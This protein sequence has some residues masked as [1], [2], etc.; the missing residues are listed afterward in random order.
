MLP[1][2]PSQDNGDART[3]LGNLLAA[4]IDTHR[5]RNAIRF[6][7]RCFE[8]YVS[9]CPVPFIS[10]GLIVTPEIR[11]QSELYLPISDIAAVF[12]RL[13]SAALTYPPMLSSTPFHNALS[14]ADTFVE[15]P[16]CLQFSVNPALLLERLL[17]DR[18]LLT[19]F[20]LDSFLPQRFCGGLGR[21]PEQ[22]KF[23]REWLATRRTRTL[24]CL[25]AA[26]GT[27]EET[28]GLALLLSDHGFAPEE[29]RINGWTLEPLEVWAATHRRLPHD[30]YRESLLREAASVPVQR[31]YDRCISFSC[32]DI[33]SS[34]QPSTCG[35]NSLFDLILCNGLLGGPIIHE[36]E[37]LDRAA[38]HLAA[39][40]S[41]GGILLAAD[42]FHGGWKQKCPQSD[43]RA[44]FESHG[45][46]YVDAGEGVG[47]LKPD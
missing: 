39:L 36:K 32:Q 18:D 14:W 5:F 22:Q 27:G 17:I 20:L 10:P 34:P 46:R 24:H 19:D 12:H 16:P 35:E 37:A 3:A 26:C 47:G 45:F 13:Y 4:D 1:L 44:L 28:Y 11:V 31:G 30:T 23:I 15:L 42:H 41:P 25:D 21:Y 2:P 33:L 9:T 43:L 7:H 40:L 8:S 29:I 38:G 6:L